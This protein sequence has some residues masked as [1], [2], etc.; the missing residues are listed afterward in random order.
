MFGHYYGVN[1]NEKENSKIAKYKDK[2]EG[3][4]TTIDS[5]IHSYVTKNGELINNMI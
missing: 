2:H 4:I 1:L 5:K 3:L